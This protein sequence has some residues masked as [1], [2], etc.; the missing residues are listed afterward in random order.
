MQVTKQPWEVTP[1]GAGVLE[2]KHAA[3]VSG[4]DGDQRGKCQYQKGQ[5]I[6]TVE[7]QEW[8]DQEMVDLK[9]TLFSR[10]KIRFLSEHKY[11]S[12]KRERN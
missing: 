12:S 5:E 4:M 8:S 1:K 6:E 7:A 9:E 11:E 10:E 2:A 3:S